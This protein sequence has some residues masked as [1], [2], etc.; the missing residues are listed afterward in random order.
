MD[1]RR[2]YLYTL[3]AYATSVQALTSF[4][5][6]C[7]LP[8][9]EYNYVQGPNVRGSL[10]IVWSCL[11]TLIACTYTVLH[12]NVPVQRDGKDGAYARYLRT[13]WQRG[14]PSIMRATITATSLAYPWSE[15]TRANPH[16]RRTLRML[17]PKENGATGRYW[18]LRQSHLKYAGFM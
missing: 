10:Q 12:L 6:N 2:L 7:T 13:W 14:D 17:R 16:L 15:A 18:S 8:D 5:T 3:V 11:A 1:H 4:D 9:H